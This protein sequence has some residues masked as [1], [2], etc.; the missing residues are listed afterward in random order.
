[1]NR[2]IIILV[3]PRFFFVKTA[4]PE[5]P[6]TLLRKNKVKFIFFFFCAW[7]IVYI[8][9]TIVLILERTVINVLR[10]IFHYPSRL[11]GQQPS[12]LT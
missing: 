10:L 2:T 9:V 4:P 1:M 5:F 8:H 11:V 3:G 12:D 7:S 6:Q